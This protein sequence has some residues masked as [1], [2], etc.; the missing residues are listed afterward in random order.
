MGPF[1]LLARSLQGGKPYATYI[2]PL[3]TRI[4]MQKVCQHTSAYITLLPHC[5]GY[6]Y[7]E[8]VIVIL[9]VSLTEW[10]ERTVPLRERHGIG[11]AE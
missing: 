1:G 6:A 2:P 10:Q 9:S 11:L 7:S 5:K 8:A 4:A 3:G